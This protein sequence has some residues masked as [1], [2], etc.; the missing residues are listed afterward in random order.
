MLK[1]TLW[2]QKH[3]EL[4]V[5]PRS[6]TVHKGREG[7]SNKPTRICDVK[8][9]WICLHGAS[10]AQLQAHIPHGRLSAS[11]LWEFFASETLRTCTRKEY[12]SNLANDANGNEFSK[13]TTQLTCDV[14]MLQTTQDSQQSSNSFHLSQPFAKCISSV[15]FTLYLSFGKGWEKFQRKFPLSRWQIYETLGAGRWKQ[16]LKHW[17][18]PHTL[19]QPVL[20][21]FSQIFLFHSSSASKQADSKVTPW[22]LSEIP[23]I[24]ALS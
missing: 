4:F 19:A 8:N 3:G 11:S 1:S 5:S 9:W 10:F 7:A 23:Q 21:R 12:L 2:F 18:S 14:A 17:T 13:C 20:N 16:G 6:Y 15:P 22:I 24:E